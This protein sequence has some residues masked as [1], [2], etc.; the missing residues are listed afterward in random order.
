MTE[1]QVYSRKNGEKQ[2]AISSHII[3]THEPLKIGAWTTYAQ[4][5]NI[6]ARIDDIKFRKILKVYLTI[7]D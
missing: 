5:G 3:K 7:F 1:Y 2:Y 6:E 4:Y